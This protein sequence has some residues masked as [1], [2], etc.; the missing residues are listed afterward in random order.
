MKQ[1]AVI[2][3]TGS[4]GQN[5]LLVVRHLSER[6]QIFALS[7]HSSVTLLA[8]QIEAFNPQVVTITDS[9]RL[10]ELARLC[11]ERGLRL[12]EM[13]SG[14]EGLRAIA[15]APEVDIVVSGA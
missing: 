7:A 8:D 13:L 12:P 9:S 11:R 10:D 15:S 14:D 5:T 6:F 1:I 2:G 3:S 4:I